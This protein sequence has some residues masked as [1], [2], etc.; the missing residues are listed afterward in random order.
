MCDL[1][2][3]M[4]FVLRKNGEQVELVIGGGGEK[5]RTYKVTNGQVRDLCLQSMKFM[6]EE[7]NRYG[8]A[9]LSASSISRSFSQLLNH[10]F[11]SLSSLR[12]SL[13]SLRAATSA[14]EEPVSPAMS[15]SC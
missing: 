10:C 1:L 3:P 8:T 9:D 6:L 11:R 14:G 13:I 4:V 5:A 7:A 2:S 12:S 15:I